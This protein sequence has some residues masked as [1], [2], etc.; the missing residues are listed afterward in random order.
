MAALTRLL[1]AVAA[2]ALC[3]A[4]AAGAAPGKD[5][6]NSAATPDA[7]VPSARAVELHHSLEPPMD[8]SLVYWNFGG[9][10][11]MTRN[12]IRLTPAG[13]NRRGYLYNE[14]P[15]ESSSWEVE[16]EVLCHSRPHFGGDGFGFWMLHGNQDPTFQADPE[17]LTGSVFGLR[18][19]FTG[20]GVVFDIYDNDGRRDN[21]SV[22]VLVNNGAATTY[23]HDND[24]A[25]D[26]YK[27]VAPGANSAYSCVGNV[28][29][30]AAPVK[31][32][33]KFLHNIL[34]VY[35]DT[36]DGLGYK[37]CLAVEFDEPFENHHIAFTGHTG[38]VADAVDIVR[39]GT[40]YLSEAMTDPDDERLARPALSGSSL[41]GIYWGVVAIVGIGLLGVSAH[42]AYTFRVMEAQEIDPMLVCREINGSLMRHYAAHAGLAAL[43]LLGFQFRAL[44]LSLPFL[45]WRGVQLS[46]RTLRLNAVELDK[47]KSHGSARRL[48]SFSGRLYLTT[49]AYFFT[50]CY[51]V[52]RWSL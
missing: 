9:S 21:P 19:D 51:Y 14:Y 10:S 27:R 16:F 34:H 23:N 11:V 3:C 8:Q 13:Q 24:Y 1:A 31:V 33:V 43:L 52:Y 40:K 37:F 25:D 38:Q 49:V 22:F 18:E 20:V 36:D 6:A 35:L 28:R 48:L 32:M 4:V 7:H 41:H 5:K 15:V 26:M 12:K 2:A 29:N 46:R 17:Y 39:V 45:A 44:L 47:D 42:E 50:A 30:T